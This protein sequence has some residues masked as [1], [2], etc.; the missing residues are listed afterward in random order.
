MSAQAEDQTHRSARHGE[1][2]DN[3]DYHL[4]HDEAERLT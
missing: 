1:K 3:R 2:N 4:G